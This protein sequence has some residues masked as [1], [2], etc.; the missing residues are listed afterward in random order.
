MGV[1]AFLAAKVLEE[2]IPFA[3]IDD[4]LGITR[5]CEHREAW[6]ATHEPGATFP[7][8][9]ADLRAE[10]Q[11]IISRQ[12]AVGLAQAAASRY[13][14]AGDEVATFTVHKRP[15]QLANS[16]DGAH[17]QG[18]VARGTVAT[19]YH[20]TVYGPIAGR[21]K[22]LLLH[23]TSEYMMVMD[24]SYVIDGSPEG[25]TAG[26]ADGTSSLCGPL[27]N[28]PPKGHRPNV[29][30]FPMRCDVDSLPEASTEALGRIS[31]YDAAPLT[32]TRRY[33]HVVAL[34]ALRDIEDEELFA[35]YRYDVQS[36]SLP[37]WYHR[38]EREGDELLWEPPRPSFDWFIHA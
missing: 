29:M 6:Q 8:H 13:R 18:R 23:P 4:A 3:A 10:N 9:L 24:D 30:F 11:S 32:T 31:R 22:A 35:D 1:T 33:H 38:V 20:G 14:T 36:D 28:H 16:G 17:V 21:I 2:Q 34:I 27:C 19:F 15:S 5:A 37:P 25:G 7:A 12:V 26:G